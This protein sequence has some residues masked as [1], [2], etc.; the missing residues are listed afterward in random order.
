MGRA[1]SGELD[2]ER[3]WT[4]GQVWGSSQTEGCRGEDEEVKAEL[5]GLWGG[6]VF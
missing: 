4:M 6:S 3:M 2:I 1:C 5:W